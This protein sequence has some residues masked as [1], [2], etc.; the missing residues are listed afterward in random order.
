VSRPL[1]LGHRGARY[2][3]PENTLAAFDLAL[4]HGCDG[5]EFD[6]RITQD[7]QPVICHDPRLARRSIRRSTYAQLFARLARKLS[8]EIAR[9][10]CAPLLDDVLSRFGN[11][12]WL[13]IEVKVAGVEREVI[14]SLRR[15]GLRRNYCVSSFRP[16]VLQELRARDARLPLG[17]LTEKRWRIARWE[18][19]DVQIVIPH[20]RLVSRQLVE[21]VHEAGKM[22]L[23]W[24]VNS[25]RWMRRLADLGVDGIVS[26][27]TELLVR[28]LGSRQPSRA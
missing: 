16:R 1:L 13:D 4:A 7:A 19:Y 22:L 18:R 10:T 8:P 21:E 26:D 2:A 14:E 11:R 20:Y 27:D 3:A 5:F 23:T 9:L 17:F 15:Q 28:T 25:P 6:V 12:A 24:T